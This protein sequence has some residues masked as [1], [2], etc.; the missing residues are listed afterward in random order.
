[1]DPIKVESINFRLFI[2]KHG[3]IPEFQRDEA[4]NSDCNICFEKC[5][6]PFKSSCGHYYCAKCI[7]KWLEAQEKL[8]YGS[9]TCPVCRHDIGEAFDS[10]IIGTEIRVPTSHTGGLQLKDI[11]FIQDKLIVE[12]LYWLKNIP[13][14]PK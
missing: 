9:K 1:M 7:M 10:F 8:I 11:Q 6:L 13:G 12:T 3:Q 14:P 4:F 5:V 2:L